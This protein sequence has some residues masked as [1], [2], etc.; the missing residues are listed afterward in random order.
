VPR[1]DD[2]NGLGL[3]RDNQRIG[4]GK[5]INESGANGL[6]VEGKARR[7]AQGALHHGRGGG[8]GE[9]CGR[10]GDN[11]R[12]EIIRFHPRVIERGLGGTHGKIRGRL[13]FGGEMAALDARARDDPFVRRIERLFK[14]GVGNDALG[15]VVPNAPDDGS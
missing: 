14:L 9:I 4:V 2:K 8:E 12:V 5:G 13:A 15:Q 7:I 3:T 1:S 6:N 11:D 10:G